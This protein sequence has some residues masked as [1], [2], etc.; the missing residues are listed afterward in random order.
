MGASPTRPPLQPEATGADKESCRW[1]A[2]KEDA[3]DDLSPERQEILDVLSKAPKALSPSQV[4]EALNKKPANIKQ[5]IH[6]MKLAGQ[7]KSVGG[8]C[9]TTPERWSVEFL[10]TDFNNNGDGGDTPDNRDNHPADTVIGVI[11]NRPIPPNPP[12][13]ASH[14]GNHDHP[15]TPT[16]DS[17]TTA[18]EGGH[19][20][21]GS[22]PLKGETED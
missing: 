22:T 13:D 19:E 18:H 11:G 14:D 16:A 12:S 17:S 8:G 9:Y 21:A 15:E 5:L 7:I 2:S 6:S 4:A 10:I 3:T 20:P 1:T